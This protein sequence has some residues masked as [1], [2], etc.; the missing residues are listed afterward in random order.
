MRRHFRSAERVETAGK[1]QYHIGLAPA[2]VAPTI[3]LAGDPARVEKASRKLDVVER[4]VAN[5]EF[6]TVTGAFKG[7]PVSVMSTGIG[8]DNMEIAVVELAQIAPK[9]TLLRIGSC[10]SLTKAATVGDLIVSSAAVRLE[11]TTSYFVHEGYPAAGDY[12]ALMA[13]VGACADLRLRHVVGI[14]ASA[15]GFYGAQARNVPGFPPRWP[16][17]PRDLA[18]QKV[19]NFEM[20]VSALFVMASLAGMRAGA[21]CAVFASRHEDRF[22]SPAQKAKAEDAVIRA[23]LQAAVRLSKLDADKKRRRIK[24]WFPAV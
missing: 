20:E 18:R 3:L 16:D 4:R 21:V 24:R 22:V 6:V 23:G 19:A 7:V 17:L 14:T 9:A 1:R 13:L 10:G 15:P 11:N 5:R 12:E 2:D 8:P